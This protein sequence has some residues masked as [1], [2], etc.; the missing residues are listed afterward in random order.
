MHYFFVYHEGTRWSTITLSPWLKVSGEKGAKT[1]KMKRFLIG[2]KKCQTALANHD[3][4]YKTV[5]SLFFSTAS[6][7]HMHNF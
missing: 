1:I 3:A 2:Y 6:L 5:G 4:W 7:A